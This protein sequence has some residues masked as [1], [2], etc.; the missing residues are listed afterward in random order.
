MDYEHNFWSSIAGPNCD[1]RVMLQGIDQYAA[2]GVPP[3]KLVIA[4][5]T[6][7]YDYTCVRRDHLKLCLMCNH[8][9]LC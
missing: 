8:R 6:Y 3:D 7:G 1:M 4:L 9:W 5:P 2:L